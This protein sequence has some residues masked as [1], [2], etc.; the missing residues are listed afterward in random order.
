M[1]LSRFP[2]TTS[3]DIPAD[4]EIPSHQWMLRSGMIRRIAAGVY[5]WS[6]LGLK[7]LRHVERIVREEMEAAGA[8]EV[9]MPMVQP[10]ELWQESG[11]WDK[12]GPELLRLQDRHHRDFCLGPTH[13]EV[14]TDFMRRELKSYRQ[15]PLNLFQIQT[16]FRD[17]TRPRF[18]VMRSRE[19]LMKD[20]YSFHRDP[21]CL[22]DTYA[23][24][25]TAYTHILRRIGVDFR[26][27]AADSGNIGGS[28]SEEFHVLA[29]TGEDLLAISDSGDFAANV[30]AAPC[31]HP[32]PA[33]PAP[34]V[35]MEPV[36]T[37]EQR[38]LEDVSSFLKVPL[39]RCLKALVLRTDN[40]EAV[41]V[42]LRGDHQLNLIKVSR[43]LGVNCGLAT[44]ARVQKECG[45]VPGFVGPVGIDT[46]RILVDRD[47][48]VMADFVCGANSEG[49]HLQHVNWERDLPL[50]EVA[51]L[52]N[53]E[54]GELAPDGGRI[55][56]K[57]GIEVGH[58]FELGQKYSQSMH[59]SVPDEQGQPLVPFMGCYGVGVSRIVGAVIEQCHDEF[60]IRWPQSIA[61]F[62]VLIVALNPKKDPEVEQAIEDLYQGLIAAGVDVALDDRDLRPGHRFAD[63]DLIGIPHRIVAG[64]RGFSTQTLEYK[65]RGADSAE[66]IVWSVASVQEKLY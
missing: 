8:L 33:R 29:D 35:A 14:V 23:T 30:E 37:P 57:R 15:L 6:P 1:R 10:A 47:A 22:R 19:F 53:I 32:L 31:T 49:Q 5:T 44:E 4:A 41:L 12:M 50:G 63:A 34:G 13:E 65:R 52:R 54:A 56:L 38:T 51:D 39:A 62:Q 27:V 18:G 25:R 2:I 20:A 43:H 26:V 45:T 60:G 21:D 40:D 59:L 24:M 17:E 16:K 3:K 36:S 64:A 46:M 55:E 7:V 11:R 42:V 48:S 28:A 58:I 9:L 66:D 61:P